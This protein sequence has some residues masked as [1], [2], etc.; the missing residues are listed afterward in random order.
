MVLG[1]RRQETIDR[2]QVFTSPSADEVSVDVRSHRL[3]HRSEVFALSSGQCGRV[4]SGAL[5]QCEL[6]EQFGAHISRKFDWSIE[7][8][9]RHRTTLGGAFEE[10]A[11]STSPR[12]RT[13]L[14]DEAVGEELVEGSVGE[15]SRQRPDPPDVTAGSQMPRDRPPMGRPLVHQCQ[16]DLAG[17]LGIVA[18]HDGDGTGEV[19]SS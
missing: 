4:E 18:G 2:Q 5:P 17:Q 8:P 19:I 10:G 13:D 15:R 11:T 9:V 12:C 7:P 6:Q 16:T 1:E 3:D 14:L